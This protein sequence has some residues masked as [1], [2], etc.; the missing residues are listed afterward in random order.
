MKILLIS[1]NYSPEVVGVSRYSTDLAEWLSR[2]NT[3]HVVTSQPYFPKWKIFYGFPNRYSSR[4]FANGFQ[5]FRCPIYVPRKPL[6][7]KR[8]VHL[9]SFAITSAPILFLHLFWSPHRII[10]VAPTLFCAPLV[11]FFKLLSARS[12]KTLLH[13]QDYEFDAAYNLG[14]FRNP[15]IHSLLTSAEAF[16]LKRF[17]A[18]STISR[19]MSQHAIDKG[20]PEDKLLMFPN[21]VDTESIFPRS[22]HRIPC[23]PYVAELDIRADSVVLMYSGSMG[24]K[25]GLSIFVEIIPLLADLKQLCWIFAGDGAYKSQFLNA[26]SNFDN[27]IHLSLQPDQRLNDLLALADIH[28]IPQKEGVE[29]LVLPSKLITILASGRPVVSSSTPDSELA[30]IS[31]EAGLSCPPGHPQLFA[32]ALRT[33]ITDKNLRYHKGRSARQIA[34]TRY[35]RSLV[36]EQFKSDLYALK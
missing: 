4:S 10:L 2:E 23:N 6:F 27:I 20:I 26:T 17:D 18:V 1:L 33:L 30:L 15:R 25:Q 7:F 34:L 35:Q 16:L 21:W 22:H 13:I 28:M 19:S 14:L 31:S 36:L 11:L 5:I 24:L 32:D 9:F 29:S 8:I 12:C 3:V